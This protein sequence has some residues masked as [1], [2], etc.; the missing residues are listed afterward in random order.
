M[1]PLLVA[2]GPPPPLVAAPPLGTA[3]P[4][5]PAGCRRPLRGPDAAPAGRRPCWE[6]TTRE[7]EEDKR[8][9]FLKWWLTRAD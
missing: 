9:F 1:P 6:S 5:S 2:T 3:A 4:A 8:V 7:R